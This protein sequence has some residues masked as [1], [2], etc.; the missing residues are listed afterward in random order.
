MLVLQGGGSLG[1]YECGTYS[2]LY[3]HGIEFN[4]VAGS[5]IGGINASIIASAQNADKNAANILKDF[6][7][8]LAENTRLNFLPLSYYDHYFPNLISVV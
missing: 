3:K 1:A 7:L 4:I 8:E 6:W 2:T 5:S